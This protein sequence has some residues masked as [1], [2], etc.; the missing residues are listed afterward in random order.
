MQLAVV[1]CLSVA[2]KYHE[3]FFPSNV[4]AFQVNG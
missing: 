2:T 4:A 3:V 1:A